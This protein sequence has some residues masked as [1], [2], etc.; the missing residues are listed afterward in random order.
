MLITESTYSFSFPVLH[1]LSQE[2]S[3][4]DFMP[5]EEQKLILRQALRLLDLELSHQVAEHPDLAEQLT[6]LFGPNH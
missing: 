4:S 6:E 5:T 3:T 2:L 1:Q